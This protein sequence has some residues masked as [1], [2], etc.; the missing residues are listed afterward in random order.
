MPR[1]SNMAYGWYAISNNPKSSNKQTIQIFN[2]TGQLLYDN[3]NFSGEIIDTQQLN[4]GIYL[5]KYSDT[6]SFSIK[7]FIVNH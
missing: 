3:Q 5:L 6:K 2:Y 7:K 4:N 1:K